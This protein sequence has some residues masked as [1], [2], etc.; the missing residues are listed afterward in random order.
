MSATRPIND[1]RKRAAELIINHARE[2]SFTRAAKELGISR[3]ALYGIKNGSYCPSL[4]LMQRACQKW[5]LKFEYR[6]LIVEAATIR[7]DVKKQPPSTQLALF[8]ALGALET[9]EFEVIRAR[10]SGSAVELVLR[11]KVSA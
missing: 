3:Q 8:D 7:A 5:K 2:L 4:A 1:L 6:G 11:L 10:K 9:Q